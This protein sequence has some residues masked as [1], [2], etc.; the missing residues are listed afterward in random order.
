MVTPGRIIA[1]TWN[2]RLFP[3]PVGSSPRV[4]RP[5]STESIISS[6]IGRNASYPQ[7]RLSIE[8]FMS[9]ILIES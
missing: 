2:V 4:S 3:P 7:Y 8:C 1:G 5:S 9:Q 6:C